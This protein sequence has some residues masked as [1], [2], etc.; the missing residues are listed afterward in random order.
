MSVNAKYKVGDQIYYKLYFDNKNFDLR[1]GIITKVLN[2]YYKF[3]ME[4]ENTFIEGVFYHIDYN[5]WKP[6][7][8]NEILS[9]EEAIEIFKNWVDKSAN[10]DEKNICQ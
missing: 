8:E 6:M 2:G 4:K 5:L 3:S 7:T 10:Y 9:K 1:K